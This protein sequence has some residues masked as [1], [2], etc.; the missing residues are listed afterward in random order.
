MAYTQRLW[1][2]RVGERERERE[3]ERERDSN[4]IQPAMARAFAVSF[5]GPPQFGHLLGV[6]T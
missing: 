5:E 4:R 1:P 3:K 6:L 2:L